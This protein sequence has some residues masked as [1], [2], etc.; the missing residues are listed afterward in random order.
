MR[1]IG[2]RPRIEPVTYRVQIHRYTAILTRSVPQISN[3]IMMK[4]KIT[5]SVAFVYHKIHFYQ[6]WNRNPSYEH[7]ARHTGLQ[8]LKSVQWF[9]Y[10]TC[11]IS[12]TFNKQTNNLHLEPRSRTRGAIPPLPNTSSLRGAYLSSGT[13]PK[14]MSCDLS[15]SLGYYDQNFVSISHL[16]EIIS[17]NILMLRIQRRDVTMKSCE[18]KS[19]TT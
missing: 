3:E 13:L 5:T 15:L 9:L 10:E 1:K 2:D 17:L 19:M 11:L 18:L 8:L 7:D 4:I 16:N 14:P 6:I 12:F